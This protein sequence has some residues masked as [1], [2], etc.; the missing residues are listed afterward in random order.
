MQLGTKNISQNILTSFSCSGKLKPAYFWFARK[1]P[2]AQ[3]P[4]DFNPLA[5]D[6]FELGKT[7]SLSAVEL[8]FLDLKEQT[9]SSIWTGM[10]ELS[11]SL[12]AAL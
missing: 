5:A 11:T 6:L 9:L 1:S 10:L 2:K 12:E 7:A 4:S 8:D 3:L